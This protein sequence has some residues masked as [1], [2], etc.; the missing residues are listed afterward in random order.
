[1]CLDA[2][3][4]L[5]RVR[6]RA[7]LRGSG[8]VEGFGVRLG[9]LGLACRVQVRVRATAKARGRGRAKVRIRLGARVNVGLDAA[10]DLERPVHWPAERSVDARAGDRPLRRGAFDEQL[11]RLLGVGLGLGLG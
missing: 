4:N 5:V 11:V 6:V 7:S 10:D 2:P 1:M 9:G 8:W 3:A